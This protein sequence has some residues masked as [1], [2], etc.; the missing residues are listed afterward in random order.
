MDLLAI[1]DEFAEVL[2]ALDG[3][4]GFPYAEATITPPTFVVV[5]PDNMRPHE[6]GGQATRGRAV[7]TDIPVLVLVGQADPQSAWRELNGWV[8]RITVALEAHRGQAYDD[9]A[10]DRV[11][12]DPMIS[13]GIQYEGAAIYVAVIA[14]GGI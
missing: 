10:V 4:N 13:G 1:M 8:R 14:S 6:T 9:C 3:L 12:F 7:R 2:G 5:P 11:E